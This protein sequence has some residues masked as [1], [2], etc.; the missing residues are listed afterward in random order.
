[1]NND[2]I[3]N[4][5]KFTQFETSL[6]SKEFGTKPDKQ[7]IEDKECLI[8][9]ESVDIELS[10]IVKLPCQYDNSPDFSQEFLVVSLKIKYLN[11]SLDKNI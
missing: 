3:T 5:N 8:C 4:L 7:F 11:L 9:L 1:M 6:N 2:I 10:Q